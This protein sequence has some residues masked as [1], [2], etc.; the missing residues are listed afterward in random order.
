M[1]SRPKR[2]KQDSIGNS[3]LAPHTQ[4]VVCVYIILKPGF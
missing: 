2:T 1:L 4:G 3:Q